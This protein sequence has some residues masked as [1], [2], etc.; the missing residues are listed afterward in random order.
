[1]TSKPRLTYLR[2]AKI[3]T[4]AGRQRIASAIQDLQLEQDPD[5]DLYSDLKEELEALNILYQH[6]EAEMQREQKS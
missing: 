2:D 1:M 5:L 3:K 4:I 6:I